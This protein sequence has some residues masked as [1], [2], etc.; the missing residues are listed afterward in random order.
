[1]KTITTRKKSRNVNKPGSQAEY[2]GDLFDFLD[3]ARESAV[4]FRVHY[5]PG[6]GGLVIIDLDVNN[7]LVTRAAEAMG[8]VVTRGEKMA[9]N[10]YR[11]K[12]A[13]LICE[14]PHAVFAL[15]AWMH[16]EGARAGA[17]GGLAVE[18]PLASP[19][20]ETAFNH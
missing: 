1:M 9:E 13:Y 10:V 6:D 2:I 7:F 15:K 18:Y 19:A 8:F 17:D 11:A 16:H 3:A 14:E 4:P 20:E 12:G 5:I